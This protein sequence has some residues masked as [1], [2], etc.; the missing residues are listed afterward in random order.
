MNLCERLVVMDFGEVIARGL[1][2]DVR[3]NPAVLEAYLGK[4]AV[5]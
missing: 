1:P 4:G 5:A 2:Q 3:C